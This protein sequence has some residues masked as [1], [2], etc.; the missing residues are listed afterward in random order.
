M[1]RKFRLESV[2]K[3]RKQEEDF[4]LKQVRVAE[5]EYRKSS[6]EQRKLYDERKEVFDQLGKLKNY[7][8][9]THLIYIRYIEELNNNIETIVKKI[10]EKEKIL[11]RER[12]KMKEISQKRMILE[13]L[14]E[15][16]EIRFKKE[17]DYKEAQF[18]DQ[19]AI[20]LYTRDGYER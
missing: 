18:L 14:K 16:E 3:I 2:L 8:S 15:K 12:D 19:L 10:G 17:Q 6:E 1:K 7:N 5:E 20:N 9:R 13:K 11:R 4:Q